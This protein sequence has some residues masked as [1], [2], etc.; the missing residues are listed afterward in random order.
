VSRDGYKLY[1]GKP[2]PDPEGF[3]INPR[4]WWAEERLLEEQPWH[5]A[6]FWQYLIHLAVWDHKGR[7]VRRGGEIVIVERGQLFHS[8]RFLGQRPGWGKDRVKSELARLE[9]DGRIELEARHGG[10]LITI[11]NYDPYQ[12]IEWYLAP[13]EEAPRSRG[14]E[15]P[16][17]DNACKPRRASR[18]GKEKTSRNV[19][20]KRIPPARRDTRRDFE[21]RHDTDTTNKKSSKGSTSTT[22]RARSATGRRAHDDSST[23]RHGTPGWSDIRAA[24]DNEIW[25]LT[26]TSA[27]RQ[28]IVDALQDEMPPRDLARFVRDQCADLDLPFA[29]ELVIHDTD[30][31]EAPTDQ[32]TETDTEEPDHDR[33]TRTRKLADELRE[34]LARLKGARA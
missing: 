30:S 26:P 12:D 11:I 28:M 6:L 24:I 33:D 4:R 21:T 18:Q 23:P 1:H 25:E 22:V 8:L 14:A 20:Q 17:H 7:R 32:P 13:D 3:T 2:Y 34:K 5:P 16:R 10:T 19:T 15:D 29:D 27:R 9:E 31:G